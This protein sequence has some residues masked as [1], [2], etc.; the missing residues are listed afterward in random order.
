MKPLRRAGPAGPRVAP[1]DLQL[2][3][4][5]HPGDATGR[6]RRAARAG[7][8]IAAMHLLIPFARAAV[9]RRSHALRRRWRCRTCARCWRAD[10]A[11]AAT[12]ATATRCRRRTSARS[13]AAL[14]WHGADGR[15]PFAAAAARR[16][17]HRRRRPR[18][19]PADAGALARRPRPGHVCSTRRCCELDD[20]ESRALF[21][22]LR[23]AVR[24]AR[25]S[26]WRWGAPT[27]WYVAPRS[28]GRAAARVARPRDRPQRRPAGCSDRRRG[29]A[30][31]PPAERGADAALPAPAQRRR[32]RRAAR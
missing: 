8:I 13:R 15:L 3:G 14:G 4:P 22:A 6:G 20:A 31:A 12:T 16:R 2:V 32:A 28:P 24:R 1:A 11:A 10:A 5:V 27:R 23:A 29:A 18:L 30:G 19:G 26:R 7:R 17:R 25:A 21:D 9:R